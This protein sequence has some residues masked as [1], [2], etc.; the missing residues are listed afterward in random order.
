M[1]AKTVVVA[2]AGYGGVRAALRLD[3]E[4]QE[5]VDIVVID[6]GARQE[7][8]SLL[9]E[10]ATAVISKQ[11]REQYAELVGT[12]GVP[13]ERIFAR[14]RI[15]FVQAEIRR[16]LLEQ[17]RI[18][19]TTVAGIPETISFDTI[20]IALGSET[21]YFNIPGLRERAYSLKSIAESL[22]MRN[23]LEEIFAARGSE[24]R[25]NIVVGGAGFSGIELSGELVGFLHILARQHEI[26]IDRVTLSVVEASDD[27]LPG[28]HPSL[29]RMARRRLEQLG[30]HLYT[31]C[32]NASYDGEAVYVGNGCALPADIL[33]WT[34]GV[35]ANRIV[36]ALPGVTLSKRCLVVNEYLQVMGVP[37]AYGIGDAAVCE[38]LSANMPAT[39][40]KAIRQGVHAARNIARYYR[41]NDLG[42]YVPKTTAFIAPIGGKFAIAEIGP[43]RFAGYAAWALKML[44]TLKYLL[45]ILPMKEAFRVW[46]GGVWTYI[47]ND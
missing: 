43:L 32:P 33:I 30:I 15:R 24:Q 10:A 28:A 6:K 21:N 1:N 41:G 4:L 45:G 27:I 44:V 35:R 13:Y 23:A 2:G 14:T 7:M 40:Q 26:P 42:R 39:A 38:K 31:G 5:D 11:A 9:Y 18:D 3:R 25:I 19:I 22:N 37:Y 47:R 8:Y 17:K 29:R 12:I 36:E 20:I 34:A 16:I 46:V